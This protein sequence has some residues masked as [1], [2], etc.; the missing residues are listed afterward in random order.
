MMIDEQTAHENFETLVGG[1]DRGFRLMNFWTEAGYATS[2]NEFQLS[3]WPPKPTQ[4]EVFRSKAKR[5][6]YTNKQIQ[7][8]LELP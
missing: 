8:F 7:A 5:D 6:G 3:S 1:P 4:E 2:G